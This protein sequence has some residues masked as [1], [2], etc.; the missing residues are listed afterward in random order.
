MYVLK[1]LVLLRGLYDFEFYGFIL[2][3]RLINIVKGND[4][5]IIRKLLIS[6][7]KSNMYFI[8]QVYVNGKKCMKFV[9]RGNVEDI[10]GVNIKGEVYVY[11][12]K[13]E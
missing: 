3:L 5:F 7:M 11:E 13:L 9:V 10:K 12:V 4:F 8:F 6:G 1:Y 2:F